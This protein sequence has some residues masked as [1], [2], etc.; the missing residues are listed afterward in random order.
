[1]QVCGWKKSR[2]DVHR[3]NEER[4]K[5]LKCLNSNGKD[6]ERK[7]CFNW[8]WFMLYSWTRILSPLLPLVVLVAIVNPTIIADLQYD[9]STKIILKSDHACIAQGWIQ[10]FERGVHSSSR[11]YVFIIFGNTCW[12][13]AKHAKSTGGLGACPP[14]NFEKLHPL[15]LNMRAF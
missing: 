4:K 9:A 7:S 2:L 8:P 10:D 1:M 14:E 11:L 12:L 5:K 3:K 15:I 6:R 13:C